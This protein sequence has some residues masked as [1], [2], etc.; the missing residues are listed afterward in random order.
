MAED[1]LAHRLGALSWAQCAHTKHARRARGRSSAGSSQAARAAAYPPIFN[2]AMVGLLFAQ[3][4]VSGETMRAACSG[5]IA[6]SLHETVMR[7]RKMNRQAASA[8]CAR[9]MSQP[10]VVQPAARDGGGDVNALP[11]G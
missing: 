9:G 8:F 2:A 7:E 4:D 1:P 5:G 10:A 6:R 11:C 3:T